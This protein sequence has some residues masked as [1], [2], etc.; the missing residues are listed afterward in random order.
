MFG[1][2]SDFGYE[3][4]MSLVSG[5]WYAIKMVG[6]SHDG[7]YVRFILDD[8]GYYYAASTDKDA[9]EEAADELNANLTA[10]ML[11]Y[12]ISVKMVKLETVEDCITKMSNAKNFILTDAL[13]VEQYH[14]LKGLRSFEMYAALDQLGFAYDNEAKR[15][16]SK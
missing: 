9:V 15:W 10:Q 8:S 3:T 11:D 2:Y 16:G 1:Q 12:N 14:R 4:S 5:D 6:G 13:T 7:E